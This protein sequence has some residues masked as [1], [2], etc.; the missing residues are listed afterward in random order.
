MESFMKV[1]EDQ[2]EESA[3]VFLRQM[4]SRD[5]R[6][7]QSWRQVGNRSATRQSAPGTRFASRSFAPPTFAPSTP[8]PSR[9]GQG[10]EQ[11]ISIDSIFYPSDN[12]PYGGILAFGRLETPDGAVIAEDP[13]A[14]G[15]TE[16]RNARGIR[17][18]RSSSSRVHSD[19]NQ[20]PALNRHVID[21]HIDDDLAGAAEVGAPVEKFRRLMSSSPL[22]GRAVRGS[23]GGPGS[24]V[25]LSTPG[26][27]SGGMAEGSAVDDGDVNIAWERS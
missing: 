5:D 7:L 23:R 20:S 10:R 1:L 13:S 3:R 18:M 26:G 21:I 6:P 2:G 27:L 25:G 8:R 24:G 14:Y 12:D 22:A 19:E 4:K 17:V 16:I 11:R 9:R 15:I